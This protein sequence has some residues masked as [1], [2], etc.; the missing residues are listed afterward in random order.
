MSDF[1]KALPIILGVEGDYSDDKADPGGKTRYGITEAEARGHGYTGEMSE[2]PLFLAQDIYRQ[3]YWD[4]CRCDEMPWP[5][6][7][8]VFDA[9]VNQGPG[10]AIKMLQ[11]CLDITP[12]GKVGPITI[13]KTKPRNKWRESRFMACRAMRYQ[14]TRNYDKFGMGWLTRL[15]Q[16]WQA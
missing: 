1:E 2:L 11:Q 8:Y 13:A 15:F 5:L 10:T 16:V 7:L 4:A 3:S 14:G 6:N 12:D 9:A